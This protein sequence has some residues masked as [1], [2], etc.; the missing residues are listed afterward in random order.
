MAKFNLKTDVFPFQREGL[1]ATNDP[2]AP[3]GITV[4]ANSDP[5]TVGLHKLHVFPEPINNL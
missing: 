3:G 4:V 1:A 5:G 2:F